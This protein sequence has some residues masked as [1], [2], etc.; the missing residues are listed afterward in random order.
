MLVTPCALHDAQNS[1][2]WSL[3]AECSDTALM[4]DL[5]VAV[6]SL[7]N[8]SDLLEQH[9]GAWV[10][11]R[12]STRPARSQEWVDVRYVMWSALG[13]SPELVDLLARELQV[14]W[15]DGR[16][17]VSEGEGVGDMLGSHVG[18]ICIVLL[19]IWRFVKLTTSRW[20]TF[21]ASARVLVAAM[22][23]GIEDF[24]SY[25][26]NGTTSDLWYLKGFSRLE[27]LDRRCFVV[28]AALVSR[29]AESVQ[30]SLMRDSRVALCYEDLLVGV[31]KELKW[32]ISIPLDMWTI[33]G[34]LCDMDGG[35][36]RHEV[37][38][39]A[40]ASYHFMWRRF[41]G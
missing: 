23:T 15:A 22:L 11:L 41:F 39:A 13:I 28:K 8:S 19:R 14:E 26:R 3:F 32:L 6:E 16:L 36:L 4:R 21:G 17:C 40:H 38:E 12:R 35:A 37:I 27:G 5:F 30:V 10:A 1:F 18:Q 25:I 20:L 24:V 2:K 7:R 33:L 34:D 29:I 9:L 31:S